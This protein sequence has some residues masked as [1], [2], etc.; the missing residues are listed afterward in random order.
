[1]R[2]GSWHDR[3]RWLAASADGGNDHEYPPQRSTVGPSI[4]SRLSS[5][6]SEVR[7]MPN[8]QT[9][10]KKKGIASVVDLTDRKNELAIGRAFHPTTAPVRLGNMKH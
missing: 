7:P 6:P 10:R 8:D 3:D 9:R 2:V 5:T 4:L 1:M